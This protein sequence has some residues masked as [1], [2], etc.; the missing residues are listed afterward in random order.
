M[1]SALLPSTRL[2]V[3]DYELTELS[4]IHCRSLRGLDFNLHAAPKTDVERHTA[5]D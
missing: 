1:K 2:K 4:L 5:Q 3:S